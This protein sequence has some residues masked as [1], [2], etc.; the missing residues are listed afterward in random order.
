MSLPSGTRLG[1]YEIQS[2][3]GAGGMGEVYKAHRHAPRPHGGHQDASRAR[4]CRSQ[5]LRQR[6]E[7]EARTIAALSHPHICPLFDVGQQDGVD[8]LVMEYLEGETLAA[9]GSA[10]GAAAARAGAART[11]IEIADALDKAH[12]AGIV[13]RD[14][15]PGNIMLTKGGAKLLDFGLAK[16]N[17]APV[18]GGRRRSHADTRPSSSPGRARSSARCTYMAPEQL[19]GGETDARTDIFAFG[20]VALRDG[21]RQAGVRG[22]ESSEPDRR[23]Y[24]G[25]PASLATLQPTSPPALDRLIRTCLAKDPDERWQSAKDIRRELEWIV[26]GDTRASAP[27]TA[28]SAPRSTGWRRAMALVSATLL[29]GVV[30]GLVVWRLAGPVP[31][32]PAVSRFVITLPESAPLASQAG[33]DLIISPDGRRITY[34]AND[35]ERGRMLFMRDIDALEA[36]VVPGTENAEDPFFS[37]GRCLDRIRTRHGAR[38]GGD[39]RRSTAGDRRCRPDDH[40][41]DFRS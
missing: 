27:V 40:R 15:K 30:T 8:F 39:D 25:E 2:A 12:R 6:F 11:A 23:D 4:R 20:A 3:I 5:K 37:P 7:R 32:A 9:R 24:H 31:T 19:E 22:E 38:E 41:R 29:G 33:Y 26:T 16:L 13:H 36:Q 18:V 14:L 35:A 10:K 1:P 17:A 34:L 28:A 21:H